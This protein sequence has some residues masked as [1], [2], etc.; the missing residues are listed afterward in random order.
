MK[1]KKEN[2]L[3]EKKRR[4]FGNRLSICE[5]ELIS[6]DVQYGNLNEINKIQCRNEIK[7]HK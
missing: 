4:V 1:K 7:C 3:V 5:I 6:E 2:S